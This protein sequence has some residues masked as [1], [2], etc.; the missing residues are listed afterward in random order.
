VIEPGTQLEGRTAI[1]SG[2]QVGPHV[3]MRDSEL[4]DGATVLHSVLIGA[5]V[6]ARATVGP[7]ASLRPGAR[8]GADAK[9]GSFVEIT[10]A[11]PRADAGR[12]QPQREGR[13]LAGT[14]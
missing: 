4:G 10:N 8:V 14:A 7:F 5:T 9:A 13:A 2:C 11:L 12:R 3:T 1:G 6:A